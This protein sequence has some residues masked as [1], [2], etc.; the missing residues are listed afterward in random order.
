[1]AFVCAFLSLFRSQFVHSFVD[2]GRSQQESSTSTSKVA[3]I[4]LSAI[5]AS[6]VICATYIRTIIWKKFSQHIVDKYYLISAC[7]LNDLTTSLA[8][9][10]EI[11]S[12]DF[13]YYIMDENN[14]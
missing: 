2:H 5:L 12:V 7:N 3:N 4:R 11:Q 13:L 10:V 9:D 14:W 6:Y 1:M 8:T